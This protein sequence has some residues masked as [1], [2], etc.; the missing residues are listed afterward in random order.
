M[1]RTPRTACSRL[2]SAACALLLWP[3]FSAAQ[4]LRPR[5]PV[6]ELFLTE[7]VY[8]QEKH[9]V[10]L[11]FGSFIDRSADDRAALLPFGVEYGLTNRWQIEAGWDLVSAASPFNDFR[12]MRFSI[13]TKYAFL[14]RETS[15]LHAAVGLDIEFPRA[16]ALP[17]AQGEEG[18]EYEPSFSLALDL[19]P[20]VT[21]VSSATASIERDTVSDLIESDARVDDIGTISYG[22]LVAVRR[23]TIA[24]EYSSR[25]DVL[26]WRVGGA[27]LAPSLIVRPAEHWELSG[28]ALVSTDRGSR[29]PGVAMR[30][31][32]E[33]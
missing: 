3:A 26:P 17:A 2:T 21:L 4:D 5:Q 19:G 22:V 28:S 10:Q 7:T 6:Q 14:N 24:L 25:S 11:T 27:M 20:H 31:V 9:E 30:I 16:G 13:G 8:P 29:A 33:F 1:N 32:R 15:P 18:I 23:M 12:T